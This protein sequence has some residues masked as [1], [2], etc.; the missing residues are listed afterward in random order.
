MNIEPLEPLEARIAPATLFALSEAN[1]LLRFDSATP[2]T[3]DA[4][5]S[6]T[7][8]GA[9]ESL[10]GIDFRPETSELFAVSVAT[11][12]ANNSIVH[13]YVVNPTTG[14]LTVV[15]ATAAAL[16]GAG[17]VPT[18][19]DFNPSVDR[20]R[21]VNANN[22]NARINPNNGTLAGNDTDLT[23]TA[24]ATGPI[25]GEAYDR[26]FANTPL[27][28]LYGIDR[29][30][31][32]LVIQGGI[33]GTPSP[34]GGVATEVGVLGITLSATR[35][36]GFDIDN[37]TGIA[38]AALT[39]SDNITRLYSIDLTLGT[40][41]SL[42]TIGNGA[43]EIRSLSAAPQAPIF[44][45][46]QTATYLDPEGDLVTV[47]VSQGTLDAGNFK[48]AFK[49]GG[50]L[51]L[52]QLDLSAA[53]FNLT[54]VSILAKKT[55]AGGDSAVVVGRI[56]AT[57]VDL[58][59]VT[60]GGDLAQID[61]G[62]G[63]PGKPALAA[64][65]VHSLGVTNVSVRLLSDTISTLDGTLG[66]L[67]VKRDVQGAT[68]NVT[69]DIGK[70]T[71]GGS[72]IGSG[73]VTDSGA[74]IAS[75]N[76]GPTK[77]GGS[78]LG[79]AGIRSGAVEAGGTLT[80]IAIG[81]SL[82][83][84]VG[85][86]SGGIKAGSIGKVTI[87][88]DAVCGGGD[89]SGSVLA[90]GDG[91][92]GDVTISGSLF[93]TTNTL[94]GLASGGPLGAVKIGGEVR[95]LGSVPVRISAEG[96]LNPADLKTALAIK[97]VTVARGVTNALILGGYGTAGTA[98]NPDAQIGTVTVNGDWTA[99]SLVTGATSGTDA[100]FGNTNDATISDGAGDGVVARIAKIV[101][102][103][104]VA[105][106]Y[107]TPTDHFG[108]VAHEIGSLMIG[109]RKVLLTTGPGNDDLTA[110]DPL[111]LLAASG[112]VRVHETAV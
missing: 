66:S 27:T 90:S 30:A 49:A 76:I 64:L 97:S 95:G 34:N 8:F 43:S 60:V 68:I 59:K 28:T 71:I 36:G 33:D 86:G 12:S 75:G 9:G 22:E 107:T 79:T 11:G 54:G 46:D 99:S 81:G 110:G 32:R 37:A 67:T 40:A 106:S 61:A 111:L 31:S 25:I 78:L 16:A 13:T 6:F 39:A 100:F 83:G 38:Y 20:L 26:N 35:D 92:I 73:A 4:T 44:V 69:G 88:G 91:G 45:N 48:L 7:G 93:A 112:D 62:D 2:G 1:Q 24:P 94:T 77:I 89:Y 87:R 17:D 21:Y 42:G 102:K 101:I 70:V 109:G 41:A 98:T 82:H 14:A 96:N 105:G 58:G 52:H 19:F 15:G 74:L 3:I 80:S 55:A 5:V 47:K 65:S 53:E 103:G 108:F 29:G 56:V 23:F 10:R 85:I 104:S 51:E 63:D 18:G 84:D 72:L 57:A 50:G